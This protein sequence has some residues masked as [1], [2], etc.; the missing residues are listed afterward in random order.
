M[1]AVRLSP[2]SDTHSGNGPGRAATLDAD[3]EAVHWRELRGVLRGLRFGSVT[4]IVQDGV[5]VQI[6]RTE[7]RRLQPNT[8]RPETPANDRRPSASNHT[9]NPRK[10][11]S[12]SRQQTYPDIV[13]TTFDTPLVKLNRIIPPRP[14]HSAVE[15]GI[16]QSLCQ[17]QGPHRPGDDRGG[18]KGRHRLRGNRDHRA[19]QRQHGHRPGVRGRGQGLSAHADDARVDE[20]GTPGPVAGAGGQPG[21]Y[22]GQGRHEGGHRQGPG[23]GRLDAP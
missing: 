18:G 2:M 5:V 22:A 10:E 8:R 13:Q 23:I 9:M 4:I 20:P 12:M 11:R 1:Q 17:R 3:M 7:K 15:T 19:H 6:D 16:L 14:R 21:P